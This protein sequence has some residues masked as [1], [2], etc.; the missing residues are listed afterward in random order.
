MTQEVILS[1]AAIVTGLG[2]ISGGLY[3]IYKVARRIGDAIG[4]D[5]NGRTIADRLERVEGQLWEN[6]GSSL[7]DRV[8][9][10]QE[11][12]VRTES[13]LD[14]IESILVAPSNAIA[15]NSSN[16]ARKTKIKKAS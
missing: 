10:I 14:L 13:K 3:A 1:I 16:T 5:H 2:V 4:V 8:N 6:G 12:V 15:N 9:K 11:H 7:A